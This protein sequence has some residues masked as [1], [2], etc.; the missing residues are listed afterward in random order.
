VRR[1]GNHNK[2]RPVRIWGCSPAVAPRVVEAT[3]LGLTSLSYLVRPLGL[4][5]AGLALALI[6][7]GLEYRLSL[8]HPHQNHHARVA[9]AKL[10]VGPREAFFVIKKQ[11]KSTLQHLPYTQF[12]PVTGVSLPVLN[13]A[14][15]ITTSAPPIRGR[16]DS[17]PGRLRSPPQA[18]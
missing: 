2:E 6:F 18:L 4:G 17:P 12:V 1:P 16:L 14:F 15:A 9:V 11:T 3:D 8:Y 13:W 7:W 10:W 5:L